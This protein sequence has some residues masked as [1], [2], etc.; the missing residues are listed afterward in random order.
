M[1]EENKVYVGNLPYGATKDELRNHF[2]SCG[3]VTDCIIITDR[4]TKRSKGFGFVTFADADGVK[5]ALD[6]KDK[7]DDR[8]LRVSVAQ[9]REN[10]DRKPREHSGR[11]NNDFNS[12]Y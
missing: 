3:E 6:L 9:Q 12:G 7:L 10:R 8:E 2:E 5:K 1:S 11:K 4:E